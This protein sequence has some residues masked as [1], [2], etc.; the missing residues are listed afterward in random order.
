MIRDS[1]A[2]S[3]ILGFVISFSI[4]MLAVGMTYAGGFGAVM[5]MQSSE[6][7]DNA[8]RAMVALA[9][10]FEDVERGNGPAR[11]GEIRL[12]GGELSVEHSSNVSVVIDNGTRIDASRAGSLAYRSDGTTLRYEHGAV[13]R[14]DDGASRIQSAP[15]MTCTPEFAVVSLMHVESPESASSVSSSGSV[16]VSVSKTE[17]S[18]SR[19]LYPRWEN[20]TKSGP[21]ADNVT[22]TIESSPHEA[23]WREWFES[24]EGWEHQG[25][26]EFECDTEEVFVRRTTVD[27][28]LIQ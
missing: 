22:V 3:E 10:T 5:D 15:E 24:R 21:A 2:V 13:I 26:N 16:L 1:R 7:T 9:E 14:S 19:L 28:E 23:A 4:I 8:E 6:R 18:D 12:D 17:L 25:G 27:V 11:A 20:E